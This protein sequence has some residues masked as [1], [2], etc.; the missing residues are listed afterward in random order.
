MIRMLS[1]LSLITG[2]AIGGAALAQ[3]ATEDDGATSTI[4]PNTGLDLGQSVQEDPSYVKEVYDDWQLQCFRSDAEEDPCQMY[5]L[6]REEAGNPVA[7]FSIFKLPGDNAVVA[8]ATVVVPLGT[9][10]PAGLQM[11][12][13]TGAAKA[14]NYS[15]CSI[16]G[17]FARIGFTQADIDAFKGGE[18]VFIVIAPAQAPD[19]TVLIEASLKGFTAAFDNVT[20]SEQ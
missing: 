15:F 7:E 5:Q 9:L 4:D 2:L 1:T 19:E 11:Y 13:D 8:G 16:I 3:E 17:C 18:T 10:L 6:L 12:V 20:V 14:Y